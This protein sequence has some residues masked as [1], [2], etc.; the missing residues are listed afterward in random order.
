MSRV[1]PVKFGQVE[2]LDS[3]HKAILEFIK[4][5]PECTENQVVRAMDVAQPKVCSKMTT[6]RKLDELVEKQEISDLLKKGESGFHKF[7]INENNEFNKINSSLTEIDSLIDKMANTGEKIGE[8]SETFILRATSEHSEF[9]NMSWFN[10]NFTWPFHNGLNLMLHKLLGRIGLK[11]HSEK[12]S[13]IL[14]NKI[15]G[16]LD[17]LY[18]EFPSPFRADLRKTLDE[19]TSDKLEKAK[20]SPMIERLDIDTNLIDDVKHVMENFNTQFLNSG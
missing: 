4:N 19:Y 13:Q 17:K 11:I 5:N 20:S 2:R 18:S 16:V 1:N 10:I 8:A 15:I 7:I 3:H 6:L 12:D 9:M 14:Y